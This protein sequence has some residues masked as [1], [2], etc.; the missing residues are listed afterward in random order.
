MKAHD[1]KMRLTNAADFSKLISNVIEV[2]ENKD[3]KTE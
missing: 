1:G 2:L 3:D